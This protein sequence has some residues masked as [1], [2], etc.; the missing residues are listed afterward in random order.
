MSLVHC[1]CHAV[2]TDKQSASTPPDFEKVVKVW[3]SLTCVGWGRK[4]A[5]P[6]AGWD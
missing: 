5:V 3:G 1:G 4:M 2:V 6:G